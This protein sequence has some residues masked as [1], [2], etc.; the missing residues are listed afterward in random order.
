MT[1]PAR[2]FSI[3]LS[4][5]V[6]LS[7]APALVAAGQAAPERK[8][9]AAAASVPPRSLT[10]HLVGHAHIDLSWLWRWEETVAD[11]AT[12][13][14]RGTLAQMD[15]LP[16]LTFAQ[17]QAA[18]YE[19]VEK[20][21]PELFQRIARKV[22]EGTWVPVGGMWVEPDLNMPDGE[23]LAR[24]LL[25]GKRYFLD[26]FGVDVKVGWNPD[27]FGHNGQLPQILRRAGIDSY[28]FERCPPGP[29][30]TP[31]FWWEGLDGSRL[32]GYVPPGWYLVDLREGVR[33]ILEDARKNT[34][35][36]DFLLLYGAG[37]HGG[38][39][40]D[41]DIAAIKKYRNDPNEPRLVFDVPERYFKKIAEKAADFPVVKRELN[42]TFPACYTT[43]AE[44]KK[45]NR[46]L[47]SLLLAAENFSAVA[48]TS[49]YRDYYPER[50]LDEA[51]KIVLRNQFHDILDGSSIGPVYDE[52]AGFYGQAR[53]RGERALDF[54]LETIS[55][56][57]DTRGEGFPVVV[58]NPLS[59]ERTEPAFA[60]VVVPPDA[61]TARAWDG[62]VRITDSEGNGVPVQ[63]LEKRAE[64][65]ATV[66]RVV[67]TAEAVPSL[68]YK[69]YRVIPSEK[70]WSGENTLRAGA[71][72]LENEFL[73]VRLDAKTGW[74]KSLFD[75]TA[76][77]EVLAGPANVLEAIEDEPESMSAWE[78]GLKDTV[79][80]A[81]EGGAAFE[82]VERG[83]V[84]VVLR[85]KSRFRDSIFEQ[86]LT[87]YRGLPRLDCRLRLDWR[88]RNIMIKAAF[89]LDLKAPAARFE[90]PY[91]S[92]VRP[93]DGTEVPAL[94]W[95][96]V[97]EESGEYGVSLLNDCKY[98]FDV[99]GNVMRMSVVH[100]ATSPDPEADRGR[101]ELLYSL[102]PHR[103]DWKSAETTRR[104][105]E[106]GR[107][108]I[109]RVPL[110]HGGTLPK[111]H[112]F[113]R[114]EPGNVVL[115][116][117]KKEIGYAERGLILRLYEIQGEKTEARVEFPWPVE[118]EETDLIE[119]P[120]GKPVG[121]GTAISVPLAPYE[122]KTIRVTRK[123]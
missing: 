91:G 56:A 75:K 117:L 94:R 10:A 6:I 15:K 63:V 20:D 51:W 114:V 26:K 116:A 86:D 79:G 19:A 11:I 2:R 54:S 57:I 52:V 109:V 50:D 110:V 55:N 3:I 8:P 36:K 39:P 14:F 23:S 9:A 111:I 76:K 41:T 74:V 102:L 107:P 99:K 68:G 22:K 4:V 37:D 118:A 101:H 89:P 62:A 123:G 81:G 30:P 77:R 115:S 80:R 32:L 83:P 71:R 104:G 16:G 49:G 66:F 78:L 105:M 25:Y 73:R 98:G 119:R 34:G 84:R 7:I 48:V 93:A 65:G 58:Y 17:S 120:A 106:L 29:D 92:I 67:F 69:L 38:G 43:Q 85:V 70:A 21:Y 113:V 5:A 60:E 12:F 61:K 47:E 100:G 46:Q 112:S 122:I 103:G 53:Q 13:T 27:S 35:V 1:R 96:D 44:T 88:E 90:I 59:W 97:S 31:F 18:I 40:R 87:L 33:K 72:E 28:V 95:V 121:S 108:L 64:G 42:F 24:Q 45:N 82:L